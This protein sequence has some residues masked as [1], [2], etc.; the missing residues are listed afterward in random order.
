LSKIRLGKISY[1]NM[2]PVTHF[3]NEGIFAGEVDFVEQVP[4]QLNIKMSQG[5]ID[6]GAISSL[7]YAEH[8]DDYMILPDLSVSCYGDIGS[9]SLYHKGSLDKLDGHKV[10]LTNTSL[11]SVNL[12]KIIL[13]EFHQLKPVYVSMAPNIDQMLEEATGALLIGDEALSANLRFT[14]KPL[15]NHLD[16]GAE[17]LRQTGNW[18]VFAVYAVRKDAYEKYP[19]LIERI[20]QEYLR[21][22]AKGYREINQVIAAA[23]KRYGGSN[24]FWEKYFSGLSHDFTIEQQE[25]LKHYFELATKIGALEVKS[26]LSIIDFNRQ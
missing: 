7:A 24:D 16:L 25:G 6:I 13:E 4:S 20:Y 21:S 5:E 10:A 1:T 18:M 19:E 3:F 11:T 9:I 8:A 22:K 26:E 15:Y 14:E 23:I 2:W 12:L 17:W